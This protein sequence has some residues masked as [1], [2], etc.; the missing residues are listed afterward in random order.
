MKLYLL[1]VALEFFFDCIPESTPIEQ[2]PYAGEM[3][4][5]LEEKGWQLRGWEKKPEDTWLFWNLGKR[6]DEADLKGRDRDKMILFVWEPP[7]V[8]PELHD[9]KTLSRFGKV[10]TWD[11]ARVDN[12]HVFK[13]YYP[14]LKERME[15]LPP[16][17]EKKF[18]TLIGRRL[19][20][21]HPKQLYTERENTIRFFEDK[22]GEFDLYGP[23][24]EKRKF[25]N[26]RGVVDDKMAVLKNYKFA[27]CYENTRD[28]SGYISEK[29]F[30]CFA[31]GVVPVYWGASNV[32]DYIPENCFIDRRKFK[33]NQKLYDFLKRI[34]KDEYEKYLE[35]SAAFL[36]SDRAKL[37]SSEHFAETFL[38]VIEQL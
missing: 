2:Y 21:K 22:V 31:A 11:D 34:S 12:K 32:T 33:N 24:W 13:F 38:K 16:F 14:A 19:C 6:I 10:F 8:Q 18:C 30:D 4:S 15:N 23:Y 36:K 17:S 26:W 35:N 9:E 37:F 1:A 5:R 7:S 28:V 3:K 20:S 25:K 27:I 29:I